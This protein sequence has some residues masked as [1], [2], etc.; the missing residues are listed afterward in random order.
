[1]NTYWTEAAQLYLILHQSCFSLKS[2]HQDLLRS[3]TFTVPQRRNDLLR[4][5]YFFISQSALH[6]MFGSFTSNLTETYYWRCELFKQV[7]SVNWFLV[8]IDWCACKHLHFCRGTS[9]WFLKRVRSQTPSAVV[10]WDASK[11]PEAKHSSVRRYE[12]RFRL[13]WSQQIC[14]LMLNCPVQAEGLEGRSLIWWGCD[15]WSGSG[16]SPRPSR[17]LTAP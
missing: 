9:A 5:L 7:I 8:G 10:L 1:M 6:Y 15:P 12:R 17:R 4:S 2:D 16:R 14:V 3:F 11:C 13:A